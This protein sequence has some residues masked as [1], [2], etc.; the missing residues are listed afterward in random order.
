M[1]VASAQLVQTQYGWHRDGNDYHTLDQAI[2]G[3]HGA[4]AELRTAHRTRRHAWYWL[5]AGLA[6][7]AATITT[8]VV[9][10]DHN[11]NIAAGSVLVGGAGGGLAIGLWCQ[12]LLDEATEG[13]YRAVQIYNA[14]SAR[15]PP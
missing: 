4:E 12:H 1:P 8:S 2:A 7:E 10:F 3:N 15:T 14:D 9:L 13:E 5:A 6:L 11:D